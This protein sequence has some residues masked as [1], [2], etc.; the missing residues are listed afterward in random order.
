[1]QEDIEKENL[2]NFS[3]THPEMV[4][5]HNCPM[6]THMHELLENGTAW[7]SWLFPWWH[8][9]I[10]PSVYVWL[11]VN[12]WDARAVF[13]MVFGSFPCFSDFKYQKNTCLV[14]SHHKFLKCKILE[15]MLRPVSGEAFAT[16]DKIAFRRKNASS[17]FHLT[18]VCY[19]TE[20]NTCQSDTQRK[21]WFYSFIFCV[22]VYFSVWNHETR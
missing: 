8:V 13:C 15:L 20:T 14:I 16:W 2:C 6:Y 11:Y 18:S 10:C 4:R 5:I 17:A 12:T 21:L 22:W 7:F 1:M 9:R 3:T 19:W